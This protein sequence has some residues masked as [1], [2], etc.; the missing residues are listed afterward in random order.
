MADPP[1]HEKRRPPISESDSGKPSEP[2]AV[3]PQIEGYEIHDK[4]G[5]GG[6][7]TVWRATQLSTHREVALKIMGSRAFASQ[8]ARARFQREVE[9]AAQLQHP[10][11]AGVYDSGLHRHLYYYAMELIEGQHLDDYVEQHAPSQRRILELMQVVCQ[12][13]QCAH[14]KGVIHRDLKPSNVLVTREG[15]PH[16][17]DFGLAKTLLEKG[18]GPTVTVDGEIMGTLPYMSPE[19]A[20]G[21]LHLL[22]TRTDVYS[23]GLILYRLLTGK[24]AHDL[25]GTR[26]EAM[27]RIA[28]QDIRR[29][30]QASRRID[31]ELEAVLLKALARSPERRYQTA[32]EFAQDI[33][34][35]L[36][37]EPLTA[38]PPTTLY[39]IGR[40]ARKYRIHIAVLCL[41]TALLLATAVTMV[42]M[43]RRAKARK[44]HLYE[45]QAEKLLTDGDYVGA[46][47]TYAMVLALDQDS[48]RARKGLVNSRNQQD[49]VRNLALAEQYLNES[50]FDLALGVSLAARQRFSDDPRVL[51]MVRR[52]KGTT[53]L[54]VRFDLGTVLE[55]KLS[56]IHA[57]PDNVS[58]SLP[59][60]ALL[61][62]HGIDVDPGW[63]WLDISYT[64]DA[65][66]ES[67]NESIKYLLFVRRSE[68]YELFAQRI[69][70]GNLPEADFATLPE[71]LEYA[72]PGNIISL[73]PG[74]YY[75]SAD[76]R[77]SQS[78]AVLSVPNL[79]FESWDPCE[80]ATVLVRDLAICDTW[81]VGFSHL[82][83]KSIPGPG[84]GAIHFDH[85]VMCKVTN[86]ILHSAAVDTTDCDNVELASNHF[87]MYAHH[88]SSNSNS[89]RF[90]LRNNTVHR[91]WEITGIAEGSLGEEA[92][93]Q[94]L[95]KVLRLNDSP[96]SPDANVPQLLTDGKEPGP[97]FVMVERG[98][99]DDLSEVAL[100]LQPRLTEGNEEARR[101]GL[102][103]AS[104]VGWR[105]FMFDGCSSVVAYG[106]QVNRSGLTG[107]ECDDCRHVL[108]GCN[109]FCDNREE[110]NLS[111]VNTDHAIV[112]FNESTS[113]GHYNAY[114][115]N[116]DFLTIHHNQV[117]GGTTGLYVKGSDID[118]R[119]NIITGSGT[120]IELSAGMDRLFENNILAR[121]DT[122]LHGQGG[123]WGLATF[124]ANLTDKEIDEVAG[125]NRIRVDGDNTIC[126]LE[127]STQ[128]NA[129][130][131]LHVTASDANAPDLGSHTYGPVPGLAETYRAACETLAERALEFGR[132][133]GDS[134]VAP[135]VGVQLA[136]KTQDLLESISSEGLPRADE[137]RLCSRHQIVPGNLVPS[138]PGLMAYY[139]MNE[140]SGTTVVD[141]S[142][143][144]HH[145]TLIGDVRWVES[146]SG[147]GMAL[148]FAGAQ[149]SYVDLGTWDPSRRTGQLTVAAWINVAGLNGE[150]QGIIAKK[151]GLVASEMMW[152]LEL[153]ETGGVEF[154]RVGSRPDYGLNVPPAGQWQHVAVTFDG[155]TSVM[156]IDGLS[157][158]TSTVFSLGPK[159]DA[160]VVLGAVQPHGRTVDGSIDEVYIY[161]RAL[162]QYEIGALCFGPWWSPREPDASEAHY[163]Y[164]RGLAHCRHQD[165]DLA[166]AAFTS[167]IAMEPDPNFYGGRAL[168]YSATR[169][170][171]LAAADL[172]AAIELD[173]RNAGLG[174]VLEK[175]L[176]SFSEGELVARW[177]F[178]EAEGADVPDLSGNGCTATL[179]GTARVVED[180][181]RGRVLSLDGQA[182]Y[183]DCGNPPVFDIRGAITV[184]AWVKAEANDPNC[185]S[186][187]S[188]GDFAWRLQ[189]NRGGG[190]V[191][192]V[193]CGLE[194]TESSNGPGQP[195]HLGERRLLDGGWHHI[196]GVY[197]GS[198]ILTYVDGVLDASNLASG[199]IETNRAL[200][201]IGAD[202]TREECTWTGLIDDVRV[203]SRA[204][205][206]SEIDELHARTAC[207]RAYAPD[208]YDG[209]VLADLARASLTPLSV[210]LQW[211]PG[212][213]AQRHHVYFGVDPNAVRN[214]TTASPE[215]RG[216]KPLGSESYEA[217]GL[218]RAS[219][220]YW[221]ID[222][223]NDVKP[224]GPSAGRV[225]SF[226]TPDFV[227]LDDFE[228][229]DAGVSQISS[230]WQGGSGVG[231]PPVRP[232]CASEC[233]V[234]EPNGKRAFLDVGDNVAHGGRQSMRF[235]YDNNAEGFA[236]YSEA[237]M[238]MTALRDWTSNGAARLSLR[239]R[240]NPPAFAEGSDGTYK[241]S[242]CGS[243]I[244]NERDEFRYAWKRL[245]GPGAI[246]TQVLSVQN[247]DAW[248]KAG[249][250]IRETLDSDSARAAVVVTPGNGV[251]FQHRF[252][253]G[254]PS[255]ETSRADMAVPL[256]VKLK[257]GTDDDFT[258]LY[259]TDG[260]VWEVLGTTERIP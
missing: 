133:V 103:F 246:A 43:N 174:L 56:T 130:G 121:N 150:W 182:G 162:S 240:G 200:L 198:R 79:T 76:R 27:Q 220:Y 30:R 233:V 188:K 140:G 126:P 94:V 171:N 137:H 136:G 83:I 36:N 256:W 102:R 135:Q 44:V 199:H 232:F 179:Q 146:M 180:I 47:Q 88:R 237:Q 20:A 3:L 253:K 58:V 51:N 28:E 131:Y 49:L 82:R 229:Y 216:V 61:G 1:D 187:V 168:A 225:W 204:L 127:V 71:A 215:H 186:I 176:W 178:D 191:Q 53:T 234:A 202:P 138:L 207:V 181:D 224:G 93:F 14:Q 169:Q 128:C 212:T 129:A 29:P 42:S 151:D 197:D 72:L 149:G 230:S 17:L 183:V 231:E 248:A 39:F 95:D 235:S 13:V 211:L 18:P 90:V 166:I 118:V 125:N 2:V 84:Q 153:A 158:G 108:L 106:N 210:V 117:V 241:M 194:M 41:A 112:A 81:N 9:L 252:A 111:L 203:Y 31:R 116:S 257:R 152:C 251:S 155:A 196:V 213:D 60:S 147:L 205:A 172:N 7:G 65:A 239:L 259:S 15:Q 89:H 115:D 217:D 114:I 247:T 55:A 85:S 109:T 132:L 201:L 119:S 77:I 228:G 120:A 24:S 222:E 63:H 86:C 23:L 11:I 167:A 219:T 184:S 227:V 173:P 99:G 10:N 75:L 107:I 244:W 245:T 214:A 91:V 243:D 177:E 38:K 238:T 148:G 45:S 123:F 62:P 145:G 250:M 87:V 64:A 142:G 22:D 218:A 110:G 74:E 255:S 157:V 33:R 209:A 101:L 100:Q 35:Y 37:G 134:P 139:P 52:A 32:G 66:N 73:A 6:M 96:L 19:Q 159:R 97:L 165:Y 143:Q 206:E 54:R 104:I 242:A 254:G 192:F 68:A 70:V 170:D 161:N 156:Y 67:E 25:S 236:R 190:P 92:G 249:V 175:G 141:A 221:R 12:A 4:L 185:R 34:N 21:N 226:T 163:R 223:V 26:Y 98:V 124:A 5:E 16:V 105:T 113:T 78:S 260:A 208:P 48:D 258:A 189:K 80:P 57:E 160:H 40:R 195:S 122:L 46:E 69:R 59:V 154:H 193:G 144:G 50:R 8:R 164:A